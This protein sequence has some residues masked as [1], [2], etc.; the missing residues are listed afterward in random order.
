MFES[1]NSST[2]LVYFV[3]ELKNKLNTM[4]SSKKNIGT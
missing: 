1:S 3:F 4:D 2:N